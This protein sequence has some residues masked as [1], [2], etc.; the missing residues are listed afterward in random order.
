M[1]LSL[2]R[3]VIL[4][5]FIS[6]LSAQAEV[7]FTFNPTDN[8]PRNMADAV[9][10][11][12]CH[13]VKGVQVKAEMG[14]YGWCTVELGRTFPAGQ[15]KIEYTISA[16]KDGAASVALYA[17]M[18][19]DQ[20]QITGLVNSAA[21]QS[22]KMQG[23]FYTAIAFSGLAIKRMDN[24]KTPSA[25]ISQITIID[26]GRNEYPRLAAYQ[27][28]MKYA[29]PWGLRSGAMEREKTVETIEAWL[30]LRS[31]AAE[32]CSRADYLV[33]VIRLKKLSIDTAGLQD[34]VLKL[35]VAIGE[36]RQPEIVQLLTGSEK[37][38]DQLQ[39]T[40]EKTLGGIVCP[41]LGTDIFTWLKAWRFQGVIGDY[42]Y[43]EPTPYRAVYDG[44]QLAVL[45]PGVK[46]DLDSTWTTSTY[47]TDRMTVIYS[48]LTPLTVADVR[49]GPFEMT[50]DGNV[51]G[52]TIKGDTA[53]PNGW[54]TLST[55]KAILL[56]VLNHRAKSINW[57]SPRLTIDFEK[58][59][60]V[61]FVRLP[62]EL[63]N[64]LPEIARFYQG[65]LLNQPVEC[66]QIQ[67]GDKIEQTFEYVKRD[68]DWP[69]KPAAILP[70]PDLAMLSR[71]PGSKLK[72]KFDHLVL[73]TIDGYGY[74]KNGDRLTYEIPTGYRAHT[75][76]ANIWVSNTDPSV[77]KELR[78]QGCQTVRLVLGGGVSWDWKNMDK[79]KAAVRRHL[80]WAREAGL[81]VGPDMHEWIPDQDYAKPKN[82]EE[83]V[84]R[85]KEIMSWCKDYPDVVAWYDLMNEPSLFPYQNQPVKP[86]VDFMRKA[87][88]I[89][90]PSAGKT[91]ILVEAVNM[92]NPSGLNFW[93]DLG[94]S[95][96]I[97]GYHDY[98]PHMFTH[99]QT[100]EQGSAS[101]PKVLYPS[102]M[103]MMEW[104]VPSWRND[105]SG[106][107]YWDR[108]KCDQVSEPVLRLM[109]EKGYRMDCGEYGVV[110][111]AGQVS[112]RSG[113]LWMRQILQRL[114]R[115]GINHNVWSPEGA[116]GFTWLVPEFKEE[117]IRFWK[118]K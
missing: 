85:W 29:A 79:L 33:R 108:W 21:G 38:L 5:L 43:S 94:D 27:T 16:Q 99:Q 25:A 51:P 6:I 92:G 82:L 4:C 74:E 13:G 1:S 49:T 60:A 26:L 80:Q 31:E 113:V 89:L 115:I 7:K 110:G 76:G 81:K 19:N 12:G 104:T 75:A 66:V 68:C 41:E 107:Y 46:T 78:K 39:A 24:T 57:T 48:M 73:R 42:E 58:P 11:P 9:D 14:Q 98:W 2:P 96:I 20:Y 23:A 88:K 30:D 105:N 64:R 37:Q 71:N 59:S 40:L 47:R 50:I 77:Y 90:R 45:K 106:W 91:P 61:G 65:I 62:A 84:K 15:Y 86:Y 117:T 109:I 28:L 72:V 56:V 44:W 18:K 87:V 101:Y 63:K 32:V 54:F 10:V 95:N 17:A 102:F 35:K 3:V 100:V 83:F 52:N 93:E 111:Y 118:T 69:V 53:A 36:N 114:K 112:K 22:R 8:F 55:P 103:P 67:K 97:V 70:V 116:S 34:T